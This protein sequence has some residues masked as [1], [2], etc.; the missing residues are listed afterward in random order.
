MAKQRLALNQIPFVLERLR[1]NLS[2][3]A[4]KFLIKVMAIN[5]VYQYSYKNTMGYSEKPDIF[6]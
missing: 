3:L 5:A 1:K 6:M 4:C 2:V